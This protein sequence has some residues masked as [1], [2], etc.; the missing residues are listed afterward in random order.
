MKESMQ[1]IYEVTKTK[2]QSELADI[3]GVKQSSVSDAHRR[4]T[5]PASW[6]ITLWEKYKLNPTWIITGNGSKHLVEVEEK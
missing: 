3:L 5:I 4:N 2:T 1:R 6:L